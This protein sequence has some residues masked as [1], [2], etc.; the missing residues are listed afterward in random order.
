MQTLQFHR[1][2]V[3]SAVLLTVLAGLAEAQDSGR[4]GGPAAA[5]VPAAEAAVPR[6]IP[7]DLVD[8]EGNY[9]P[10]PLETDTVVR[11]Q[12][13]LDEHNH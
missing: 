6:A 13:F 12:I 5:A 10:I 7:A 4:G 2:A 9:D 8:S 1:S 11:V 3:V